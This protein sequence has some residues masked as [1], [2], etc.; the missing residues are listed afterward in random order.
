MD[1]LKL[2]ASTGDPV[3]GRSSARRGLSIDNSTG[4]EGAIPQRGWGAMSVGVA[5]MFRIV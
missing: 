5:V 1:L 3:A 2:G 4:I